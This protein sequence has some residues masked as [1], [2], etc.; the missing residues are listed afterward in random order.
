MKICHRLI[1]IVSIMFI[2]IIFIFSITTMV[3]Y[4]YGGYG[5]NGGSG[6]NSGG[7]SSDSGGSRGITTSN[8]DPYSNIFK[9]E[10]EDRNLV[11]NKSIEY[12][13]ITPELGIYQILVNGK[14]NEFSVYIR[15][16]DL[17]NTSKYAKKNAPGIVYK[18][19]N[20]WLGSTRIQYIS[21]R[22]RVKNSWIEN[23]SLND[24]RFPYL[25][26]WN[27][28]AWLVLNTTMTGKDDTYTYLESPK[29]GNSRVGIFAI[30]A[31][32]KKV[33]RI[34]NDTSKNISE[35]PEQV[36]P[37]IEETEIKNKGTP[38]GLGLILVIVSII[39]ST[40]YMTMKKTKK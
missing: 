2:S 31:P 8:I 40:I 21:V 19:E 35:D 14:E 23:N 18:N 39:A 9:Y 1:K 32:N 7:S 15:V 26:K 10:V 3:G 20:I 37:I 13:F 4:G 5:G 36:I 27:G 11:T 22:F 34:V 12:S 30:S 17:K 28:T 25:L 29:A 24:G 6:G 16:E 38:G 33:S